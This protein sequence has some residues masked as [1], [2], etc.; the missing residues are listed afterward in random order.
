MQHRSS[1]ALMLVPVSV[2]LEGRDIE[3]TKGG[4]KRNINTVAPVMVGGIV[5]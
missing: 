5:Y 3:Q 2:L 4:K 1:M